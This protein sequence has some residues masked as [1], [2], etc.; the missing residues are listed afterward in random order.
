MENIVNVTFKDLP[1]LR[2]KY[3]KVTVNPTFLDANGVNV[4]GIASEDKVFRYSEDKVRKLQG[5]YSE[6]ART[7]Q[8]PVERGSWQQ[9]SEET[10]KQR[11]LDGGSLLVV[12]APGVGKT[13][14]VRELVAKLR[15]KGLNVDIVSN[16]HSA[17]QNFGEGAV[18]ADHWVRRHVR[19][20]PN[21]MCWLWTK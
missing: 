18:T 10:A 14:W 3:Q 1:N 4:K 7:A 13:F 11:I 6:P 20:H 21:V 12:G 16:T 15:E 5:A 8:L 17:V 2:R 9:L 19:K